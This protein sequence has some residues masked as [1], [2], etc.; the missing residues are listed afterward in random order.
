MHVQWKISI[1]ILK[2]KS[3][4]NLA[5]ESELCDLWTAQVKER[6]TGE[7]ALGHTSQQDHP[8]PTL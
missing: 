4:M 3:K 7:K 6:P 2:V 1:T 8:Y 5:R